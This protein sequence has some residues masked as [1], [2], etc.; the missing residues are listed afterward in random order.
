MVGPLVLFGDQAS[1]LTRAQLLAAKKMG[2]N[3]WQV[4]AGGG[5]LKFVTWTAIEDQPYTTYVRVT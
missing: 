4:G 3:V 2:G 1:G 5:V